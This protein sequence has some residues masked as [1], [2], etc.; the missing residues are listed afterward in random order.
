MKND[1]EQRIRVG[2]VGAS[3]S[4]WAPLSHVPALKLLPEYELAA[5]CTTRADTAAEA[6]AKYGAGRA[7]HDYREMVRQPDIDLVSVV[8]K[9]PSH[10]D[11]VMAALNAGKHVYCE[12]PLGANRGEAEEMADLARSKGVLAMVGLQARGDPTVRYLRHLIDDGYIGDVLAVNM[13]MFTPGIL[14]HPKSRL[15]EGDRTKGMSIITGRTIHTMDVLCWCLGDFVEVSGKVSTQVKQWRVTG[16]DELVDVDASDNVMVN[17]VL[18]S[19]AIASVHAATIPYDATGW[20]MEIY[21]R[22]GT[23]RVTSKGSPQRDANTLL[24]S[25]NGGPMEPLTTPASFTEVPEAMPIGPPRNVGHLY[26]RMARA[27][28]TGGPVEPD[29][30]AAAKRHRLVDAIQQSSDEGR[31]IAIPD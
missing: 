8:V 6:A 27:I 31:A 14:D 16:T 29:F 10:H 28:R 2:I 26:L 15:W 4:G 19:G 25:Q 21:G 1:S 13:T 11:V 9:V 7:F 22:K 20:R 30:D 5:V 17:G 24:G 3:A 12:W 23:L 18:A